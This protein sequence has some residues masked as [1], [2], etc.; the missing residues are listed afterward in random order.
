[1]T[2]QLIAVALVSLFLLPDPSLA[3]NGDD[4]NGPQD[5]HFIGSPLL[6]GAFSLLN[7]ALLTSSIIDMKF[8]NDQAATL[9]D[10]GGD[11]TPYWDASSREKVIIG[12]SSIS[13]IFSL[14]ALRR[15]F[16]K[17]E[18]DD[19][20]L[21]ALSRRRPEAVEETTEKGLEV[22]AHQGRVR[23]DTLFSNRENGEEMIAQAKEGAALLSFNA[24]SRVDTIAID[25]A[26]VD[27]D[28]IVTVIE[29]IGT[30]TTLAEIDDDPLVD[31]AEEKASAGIEQGDPISDIIESLA[32]VEEEI[33]PA[34]DVQTEVEAESGETL[35]TA[36]N[37]VG[38]IPEG[39]FPS[40][41]GDT[42]FTQATFTLLPF[43]VHVSSFK[44]FA[45]AE[46]VERL[47]GRRDEHFTIEERDLGAEKGIWYRV[48]IGNY[49]TWDEAKIGA[50][51]LMER[52]EID[53]VQA[54]R[55]TGY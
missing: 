43:A 44:N 26:Y 20:T 24:K 29:E 5:N 48:L 41:H 30:E 6:W 37:E 7:G 52:Y 18:T 36:I 31:D 21:P 51:S 2:R 14:A 54:V 28:E 15:S 27:D 8:Y 4:S 25:P 13:L 39:S 22:I 49:A 42:G 34:A 45:K 46:E 47:W 16:Q 40:P 9:E 12:L 33:E 1:M 50:D 53:Y 35:L 55:R 23:Y 11:A 17:P 3:T 38:S 10:E 19:F 32:W